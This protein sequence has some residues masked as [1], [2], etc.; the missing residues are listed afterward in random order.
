M[1]FPID[2]DCNLVAKATALYVQSLPTFASSDASTLNAGDRSHL[3][4]NTEPVRPLFVLVSGPP[5]SGKSTIAGQIA[6]LL[7]LPLL[8]KDT[9]KESIADVLDVNDVD[10][11]RQV[12]QASIAVMFALARESPVGAV[13]DCNLR[14]TRAV[15]DV[16]GLPGDVVELFC[17][18]DWALAQQ[19]YRER[20][21]SRHAVHLDGARSDDDLWNS[22][23]TEPVGGD[24]PVIEIDTTTPQRAEIVVRR[25]RECRARESPARDHPLLVFTAP[26]RL[27]ELARR[28]GIRLEAAE[29]NY[30]GWSKL[31]VLAGDVALWTPRDHTQVEAF[32]RE[33]RALELVGAAGIAGVPTVHRVIDDENIRPYPI[34]VGDR[35]PGVPLVDRIETM[36]SADLFALG[37]QLGRRVARWHALPPFTALERRDG[38]EVI[39]RVSAEIAR[40]RSEHAE[41]A[42]AMDRS[43]AL[44]PVLVH[45]DLHE[46]QILVDANDPTRITGILDWQTARIDHPFVEFGLGE[47]GT[48]LWRAHRR[49][50]PELRR[51]AWSAYAAARGLDEGLALIFEWFHAA[52]HA[53]RLL[54]ARPFPVEH[55]PDVTGT[56][57]D[58]VADVRSTLQQLAARRT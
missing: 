16:A 34:A 17:R 5:G 4:G 44:D 50:F 21:P 58:A 1:N 52:S 56:A 2:H 36:S 46:G 12:G 45:G 3:P 41:T 32:E 26:P 49:V 10:L 51:R 18:C 38:L 28:A 19:R 57:A 55:N 48:A 9:I 40:T 7:E 29:A 33:L 23:V 20:T 43:R 25:V 42:I 22:D 27:Q 31:V 8:A 35:L 6:P 14:R 15:G 11:S 24:W 54:G 30:T 39:G 37:E 47:W 53:A 13:L